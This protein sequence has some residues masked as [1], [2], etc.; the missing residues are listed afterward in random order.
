MAFGNVKVWTN[1][2]CAFREDRRL[3]EDAGANDGKLVGSTF[4]LQ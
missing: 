4:M 1:R 3:S 2:T